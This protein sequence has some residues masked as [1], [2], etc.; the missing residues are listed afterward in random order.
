MLTHDGRRPVTIAHPVL[1]RQFDTKGF[2]HLIGII[3]RNN[4]YS[5]QH[6]HRKNQL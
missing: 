4:I 1:K 2:S 3:L 5:E 6:E